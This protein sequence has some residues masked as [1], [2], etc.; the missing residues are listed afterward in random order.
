MPDSY[1]TFGNFLLLKQ[2]TKDSFGTLWRAGEM[3]RTGFKRIVWMRRFDQ[4]GLDRASLGTDAGVAGQLAQVLRATNIVRNGTFG[5]EGGIPYMAWDYVPAQPL[6]QLLARAAKEQF[7]IAID[8]ALLIAEKLS[9]ALAAALAIEFKGEPL[10]HGFLV[11]QLVVV[12]NDGEAMVAGFGISRGLRTNFD[13]AGV[14]AMVA[15]YL[16]PEVL[17]KGPSSRR[18]DVYSLAAI[19]YQLL[20]GTPLPAD[21]AAR[22]DALV[23]PQL[24]FEEGPVPQDVLA[25]LKKALAPE[26][27]DRQPSAV[28]F[29]RDLEKL[30]YGGAYSPTTFNLA[31]FMDRLYR[32]EIE[33]EDRELQREKSLDVSGYSQAPKPASEEVAEVSTPA[34]KR[35]G[36][37]AIVG[38]AV[39]LLAVIAYLL[40]S[41][42]AGQAAIDKDAQTKMVKEMVAQQLAEEM[43]KIKQSQD[44]LDAE[45]AHI[46][47]EKQ[48]LEKTKQAAASGT[49][50]ISP[51]EQQRLEQKQR[52]ILAAE[53]EQRRKEDALAKARKTA[54]AKLRQPQPPAESQA[55]TPSPTSAPAVVAAVVP[56][57]PAVASSAPTTA[58]AVPTVGAT[59]TSVSASP[60]SRPTEQAPLAPSSGGAVRE[61]DTVDF[62]Q[63]DAP[64]QKLM[65]AK[66]VLP[67]AAVESRGFAADNVILQALVDEKGAI[68]QVRVLRG[69]PVKRLG[70]DEACIDALKQYRYKPAIKD[71]VRVKT[72]ITI[73]FRIDLTRGR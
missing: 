35:T 52:E 23:A 45:K 21:P 4:A 30:L 39:V 29:K 1:T 42:P 59:P 26:P 18:S 22:I 2:R 72:W 65:D 48:Q 10:V 24:A 34:S 50:R 9:A 6:D 13:R 20:T 53:A 17:A 61:G 46:A 40:A 62:T 33:E 70:I 43:K 36:L 71:G 44:E 49:K 5:V 19:L 54:E 38:G 7:P 51:E 60:A 12:G 55:A 27:D 16:A 37:I 63:V 73:S 57:S 66:V 14:R 47:E 8:N 25:I 15:P 32:G 64:P 31:L 56:T 68:Q 28:E 3:E 67:R 69:F 41:R 11:P 58:P